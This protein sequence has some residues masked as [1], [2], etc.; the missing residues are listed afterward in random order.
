MNVHEHRPAASA[1]SNGDFILIES[2][3]G[4]GRMQ[5][6]SEAPQFCL[7]MGSADLD[8]GRAV[9]EALFNSRQISMDEI[10]QFFDLDR[11]N[12]EYEKWISDLI[13]RYGYRTKRALFKDMK[14]VSIR[15][16]PSRTTM[17]LAPSHH[18]RLESWIR[19]KGDGIEDVVVPANSSPS[20][21]GAAL[22][23]A[24]SRCT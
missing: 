22:R 1:C 6:D 11:T 18:D 24:F 4:L 10:P 14:S 20:E 8:A 15:L 13:L 3:S 17:T 9:L 23:V 12:R 7:P 19:T 16:D 21:I 5:L 2:Y